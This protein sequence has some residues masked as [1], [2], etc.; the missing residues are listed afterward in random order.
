MVEKVAKNKRV[1]N[2]S[3]G[4]MAS[5]RMTPLG[6]AGKGREIPKFGSSPALTPAGQR[7]W[8][9]LTGRRET[10]DLRESVLGKG[11]ETK[12]AEKGRGFRWTATPKA[13]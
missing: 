6:G 5:P 2:P 8:G 7:L 3:S 1:T 12:T 13:K 9:N 4:A 11:K 10:T